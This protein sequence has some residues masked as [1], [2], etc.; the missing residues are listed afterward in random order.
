M[1][2]PLCEHLKR[3]VDLLDKGDSAAAATAVEEMRN[4]LANLPGEMEPSQ[5]AEAQML[6]KRYGELGNALR[7][8]VIADLNR[9]G[10]GRRARGYEQ[11]RRHP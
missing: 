10:A 2:H 1:G 8:R 7:E 3:I 9:L 11:G 6:M 4:C 5:L